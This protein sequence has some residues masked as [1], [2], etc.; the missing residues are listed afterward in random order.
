MRKPLGKVTLAIAM[1]PLLAGA[2]VL[3]AGPAGMGTVPLQGGYVHLAQAVGGGQY[4]DQVCNLAHQNAQS[5]AK[6]LQLRDKMLKIQRDNNARFQALEKGKGGS[7]GVSI[8]STSILDEVMRDVGGA[9]GQGDFIQQETVRNLTGKIEDVDAQIADTDNQLQKTQEDNEFRFEQLEKSKGGSGAAPSQGGA[10]QGAQAAAAPGADL[11]AQGAI[12]AGDMA[13]ILGER[14]EAMNFQIFEMQDQMQKMQED[15]ENRFQKLESGDRADAGGGAADGSVAAA[16]PGA[17]AGAGAGDAV[18]DSSPAIEPAENAPQN[19]ASVAPPATMDGANSADSVATGSN[20]VPQGGPAR[21][22]PPQS[23]GSIRFD[24]SGNVI[25][26]TINASP[27]PAAQGVPSGA[28]PG[29]QQAAPQ[30]GGAAAGGDVVASLPTDDNPNSLYQASYQYLMSGDYKAA[31]TGFRTHVKRY[32]ADPMTAD[33]R[34]WLGESLYG[35]GRYPE[36]ATVFIDT[37]R[38]YPDFKRAP[39][40][41]FK[42]GLTLE[43]MDN[44]DV[45]CATFEQIPQRYPKAAPAM[46]KRVSDERSRIKC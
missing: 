33:A 41:M 21:G 18:S 8:G 24:P 17:G 31:E 44:H 23:L 6:I 45:A 10:G 43:K 5:Y 20:A 27:R 22:E 15:N 35:Q 37:Q 42:L 19:T 9:S 2:P 39:E 14:A 28:Q 13:R 32:P 12:G 3:A 25:G 11:C 16:D 38:D 34:Y 26:E 30:P 46:L 1:L 36:A 7:R 40:N 29:G 4:R